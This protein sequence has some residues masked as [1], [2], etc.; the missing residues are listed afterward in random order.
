MPLPPPRPRTWLRDL[1]LAFLEAAEGLL[2]QTQQVK[3]VFFDEVAEDVE[4]QQQEDLKTEGEDHF[5]NLCAAVANSTPQGMGGGPATPP[6]SQL[7]RQSGSTSTASASPPDGHQQGRIDGCATP[8]L[9]KLC[10]QLES[11][12]T[13]TSAERDQRPA[14]ITQRRP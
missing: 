13:T 9:F 10:G 6:S 7:Q 5:R 12:S 1:S 3:D 14:I 2:V 4:I 8:L 11:A